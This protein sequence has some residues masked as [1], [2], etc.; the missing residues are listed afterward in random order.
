MGNMFSVFYNIAFNGRII[1]RIVLNSSLN[2]FLVGTSYY[3]YAVI[4]FF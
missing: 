2:I 4:Y 1:I 3:K